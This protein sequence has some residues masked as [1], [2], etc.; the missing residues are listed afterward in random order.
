MARR[1]TM[2]PWAAIQRQSGRQ[3]RRGQGTTS[4]TPEARDTVRGIDVS[5]PLSPPPESNTSAVFWLRLAALALMVVGLGLPLND[6]FG[7]ALLVGAAVPILIGAISGRAARWGAAIGVIALVATVQW[8]WPAPRIAE[9][10][11]VFVVDRAGSALEQ[12]LP[13]DAFRQML[14][15]FHTAYPT[16]QWCEPQSSGCWRSGGF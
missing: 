10:H 11:N 2:A 1:I 16:K 9:G 15:E 13:A 12:G 5:A 3:E 14:A 7:Y 6:L 8:L 4:T